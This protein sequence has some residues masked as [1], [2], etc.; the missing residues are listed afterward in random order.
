[1]SRWW[2]GSSA[3]D[4]ATIPHRSAVPSARRGPS[5]A[6]RNMSS[7]AELHL[8]YKIANAPLNV[9]PFPHLYIRDV[10]PADYY[11]EL[12]SMLPDPRS[13]VT[14]SEARPV[15]PGSYKERFVLTFG[16]EQFAALPEDKRRFWG[17]LHGWLVGGTFRQ[18]ML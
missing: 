9:F 1:M 2:A 12:Q 11:A 6:S 10:F 14:I 15:S 7:N 4:S 3:W 16:G 13:M 8:L 18:R 17:D 5:R